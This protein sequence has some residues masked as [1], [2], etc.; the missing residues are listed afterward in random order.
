MKR[1]NWTA[2]KIP[3]LKGK[4]ILVTGGNIGLGYESVKMLSAKGAEV[5]LACRNM[6]KGEY[7]KSK[8][9]QKYKSAKIEVLKLDLA[10]LDSIRK[11]SELVKSKYSK[12]DILINN[13]GVMWCPYKKTTDNFE[14]QLGTNHLGHFALTGLLFDLLKKTKNSRIVN[15]SSG[16]HHMGEINFDDLMWEKRIYNK[17]EAY[18]QSKIA[19]LYFTYELQRKISK[20][21]YSI[22]AVA[23]HPGR[24]NTNLAQ[25]L[26]NIVVNA[27]IKNVLMPIMTQSAKKGALPGI[28]AAVD[29][30]VKGGEY[31]GPD[32]YKERK[33]FPVKVKSNKLSH[34][35]YIA[36]RLWGI[37]EDLTGVRYKL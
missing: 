30:N 37:S 6:T 35:I 14:L 4:V 13:A 11:F 8:I 10:S 18:A 34:D 28:R 7:A 20:A 15:I 36:K 21:G 3:D 12:L 19:N 5:I 26:G 23:A 25:H 16:A 22:K 1:N 2:R 33:G 24:S 17:R 31:Y 9:L 29:P 27:I 32:G